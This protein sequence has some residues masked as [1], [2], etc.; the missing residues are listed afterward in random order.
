MRLIKITPYI[1]ILL[2]VI[3]TTACEDENYREFSNT[4]VK[5]EK[6]DVTFSAAGGTGSIVIDESE[7]SP[8]VTCNENWCNTS[9]SGNIVTVTVG[10]NLNMLGR[11]AMVTIRSGEKVNYVP[12]S[13]DPVFLHLDNYEAVSIVGK[14]GSISFPYECTADVPI[15]VTSEN[16]W[17][18]GT[19]SGGVI[20][21]TASINTDFLNGRSTK[22]KI[23]AGNDLAAV[24]LGVKQSELMTSYEPDPGMHSIEDFLNL[25]NSGTSST[26]KVVYY[27]SRLKTLF[28]NLKTAYP[29]FTEIRIQAPRGSHK[30]SIILQNTDG[31]YYFNAPN[32]L[33]PIDG[34]TYTGAF[35]VTGY[36]YSGT[37]APY[38]GN[39]N[40]TQLRDFFVAATGFTIFPDLESD[41]Y[42][43]RSVNDPRDYI[44]V[45]PAT[46]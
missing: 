46:W 30:L 11:T 17:L 8:T 40:Y 3:L 34:S 1:V 36:T 23:I 6:S 43:F 16:T 9:L 5:I 29:I 27:S 39:T 24:E 20:Q 41:A 45:E 32:G 10:P 13:Q 26:Y 2:S 33:V 19:A 42:W 14:G 25:K 18:T 28:D 38:T 35:A 12:V 4:Q 22:I 7:Q 44:K 15:K 31:I 37:Q 21:L